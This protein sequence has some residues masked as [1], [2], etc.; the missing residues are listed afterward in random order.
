MKTFLFVIGF[1]LLSASAIAAAPR[2]NPDSSLLD[3]FAETK[4]ED[5]AIRDR[6]VALYAAVHARDWSSVYDFRIASFRDA[7]AK[8]TFLKST[9]DVPLVFDGYEV[10]DY[11]TYKLGE[12][13]LKKRFIIRFQ[14]GRRTIYDVIWWRLEGDVWRVENLGVD[15]IPLGSALIGETQQ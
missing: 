10:L 3:V 4:P 6:L 12:H 11:R 8:E 14:Q 13:D 9:A 7:V 1:V 2:W 5:K 15:G